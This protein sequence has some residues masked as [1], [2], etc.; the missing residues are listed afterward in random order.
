MV[1]KAPPQPEHMTIWISI[2]HC[3]RSGAAFTGLSQHDINTL[4]LLDMCLNFIFQQHLTLTL[5][6]N[7]VD[8]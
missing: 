5:G 3:I 1:T 2:A 6:G 8:P 7:I 4:L